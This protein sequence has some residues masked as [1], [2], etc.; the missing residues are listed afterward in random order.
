LREN[1]FWLLAASFWQ[2]G[3]LSVYQILWLDSILGV[4][5]RKKLA[6]NGICPVFA[7]RQQQIA[8]R[9]KLKL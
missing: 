8:S 5:S 1:S 7:S 6:A 4:T 3:Y 2:K 9:T